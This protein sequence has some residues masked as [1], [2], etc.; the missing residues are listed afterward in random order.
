[1][2][3]FT[4]LMEEV[5]IQHFFYIQPLGQRERERQTDTET[6]RQTDRHR[7]RQRHRHR[8]TETQT[9]TDRH[10]DTKRDTQG[11]QGY[12]VCC[13]YTV[14]SLW[15]KT[16]YGGGLFVGVASFVH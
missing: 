5:Q 3:L 16:V 7:D 9:D 12:N 10:R 11:C 15:L 6:Q 14:Q 2:L 1:M 8:Q 4:R 13:R